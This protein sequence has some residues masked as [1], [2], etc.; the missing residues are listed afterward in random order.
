MSCNLD[1]WTSAA[2]SEKSTKN[3]Y[4]LNGTGAAMPAGYPKPGSNMTV[5]GTPITNSSSCGTCPARAI[6]GARVSD[7]AGITGMAPTITTFSVR[8]TRRSRGDL[9]RPLET[10]TASLWR[11]S[12]APQFN[13][14][15]ES[16]EPDH[17]SLYGHDSIHSYTRDEDKDPTATKVRSPRP[18][19]VTSLPFAGSGSG[20]HKSLW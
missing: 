15:V 18:D 10:E 16:I 5:D 3:K 20:M 17:Q 11:H 7:I 19:T 6:T 13:T 2:S 12:A 9:S 8:D 4:N 14:L 1:V